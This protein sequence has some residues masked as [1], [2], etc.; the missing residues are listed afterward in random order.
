MS[1]RHACDPS[2]VGWCWCWC[3]CT[4]CPQPQVVLH[5]EEVRRPPELPRRQRRRKRARSV[6]RGIGRPPRRTAHLPKP[7]AGRPEHGCGPTRT[8]TAETT[9]PRVC[10]DASG[11]CKDREIMRKDPHSLIEG[12]LVS[13]FAMRARAAYI[14]IRGP[15]R[16]PTALSAAER[17]VVASTPAGVCPKGRGGR[18]G[19]AR[20]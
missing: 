14:Y 10:G 5:A 7:L 18:G 19:R 2:T 1:H 12:C 6:R 8:R 20:G 9:D 17:C 3:W 16:R 4:L 13:G 11:T 15:W